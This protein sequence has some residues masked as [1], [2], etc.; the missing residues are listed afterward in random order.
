MPQLEGAPN[1]RVSGFVNRVF[2][3]AIPMVN[4]ILNTVEYISKTYGKRNIV[5]EAEGSDEQT[6]VNLREEPII[7]I[8]G[9][10]YSLRNMSDMIN[11]LIFTGIDSL[12]WSGS[13]IVESVCW[14]LSASSSRT[15]CMRPL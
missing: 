11:N 5:R 4:G 9:K 14:R 15:S 3:E 12:G 6:W 1:F 7:F 10:P 13:F 8:N 2:G